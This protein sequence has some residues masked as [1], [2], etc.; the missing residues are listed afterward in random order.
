MS[1]EITKD[2]KKEELEG[3]GARG[4]R[5]RRSYDSDDKKRGM[6]LVNRIGM[7]IEPVRHREG[8]ECA[9]V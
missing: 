3:R 2:M 8:G 5:R 6:G 7:E 1:S 4:G 9:Q